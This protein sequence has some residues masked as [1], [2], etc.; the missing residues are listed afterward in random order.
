MLPSAL[1]GPHSLQ[2]KAAIYCTCTLTQKQL[3]AFVGF[4]LSLNVIELHVSD[5]LHKIQRNDD[6]FRQDNGLIRKI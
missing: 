4:L 2:S 6:L 3:S 5:V 1:K